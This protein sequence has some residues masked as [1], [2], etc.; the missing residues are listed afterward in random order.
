MRK[1]RLLVISSAM[2]L[3]IMGGA[4]IASANHTEGAFLCPV[5]G[6]G[7]NVADGHNGDNGVSAI[8]IADGTSFFPAGD[9]NQAGANANENALNTDNPDVA[10]SGPGG[11]SDFS[12][13]WPG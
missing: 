10:G 13:I 7:V 2:A 1:I 3:A 4:S 11:N 6:D 5:V 9:A 12:P 8:G